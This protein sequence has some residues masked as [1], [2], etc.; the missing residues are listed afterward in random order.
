MPLLSVG[1]IDLLFLVLMNKSREYFKK[2]KQMIVMIHRI[3]IKNI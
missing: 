2:H 1:F 3:F